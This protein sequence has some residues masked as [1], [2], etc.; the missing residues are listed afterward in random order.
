MYISGLKLKFKKYILVV[1]THTEGEPTRIILFGFPK[2]KGDTLYEKRK[3]LQENYDHL[4]KSILLE[5]RGHDDQ[6]GALVLP[7]EKKDTDYA[8]IF[9]DNKGYEDM[10]GHGTI[11]V[12][13]AL[14]ELGMVEPIE[15]CTTITYETVA[16]LV[17]AKAKVKDGAVEEV[18]L[19]NVPSFYVGAFEVDMNGRK[20]PVDLAYGGNFYL[21]TEAKNLDTSVRREHIDELIKLG[22]E[23]RDA[24]K[25]QIDIHHP[26]KPGVPQEMGHTMI[27][28]EPE[29]PQSSG[30]NIVVFGLGQYDRS[31]CG[32]GT[33][34]RISILY[35]KGLLKPGEV[36]THESIIN[37]NFRAKIL[38]TTKV[39]S[40]DAIIPEVTGRAFVTQISQVIINPDDI[41][42]NGFSML[43]YT[44]AH[45]K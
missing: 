4:R 19:V 44:S 21:I 31:P 14:V 3:F 13:T 1:D 20:V 5:P 23:L 11:G 26:D 2:L 28:D 18:S 41:L 12:T 35:N 16:G 15:P 33:S 39:G 27:T 9:M 22:I 17:K 40:Y 10:C 30:K 6:F 37:T 32:T 25:R 43:Q 29:L 36:F 24:A 34:A 38:Q 42:K 7:S 45:K 8:I